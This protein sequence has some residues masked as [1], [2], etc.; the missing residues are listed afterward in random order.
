MS[1]QSKGIFVVLAVVGFVLTCPCLGCSAWFFYDGAVTYPEQRRRALA[2]E[3]IRQTAGDDWHNAWVT[4]ARSQGW[5]VDDPG[6]LL[7]EMDILT[8]YIIG[9]TCSALSFVLLT[10]AIVMVWL[11]R[12][13]ETE[14]AGADDA[15][16]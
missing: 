9:G 4:E 8:Q 11:S 13:D 10:T 1:K 7:T 15:T 16:L 14:P 5:P 12:R 2:Y 6:P 3:H